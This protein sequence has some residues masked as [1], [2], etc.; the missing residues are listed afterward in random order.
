MIRQRFENEYTD[1]L[2]I[3]FGKPNIPSFDP[4]VI[5]FRGRF[6]YSSD[7]R[8]VSWYVG[9]STDN[10]NESSIPGSREPNCGINP[11][12]PQGFRTKNSVATVC[13]R[14]RDVMLDPS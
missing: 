13:L 6:R 3:E 1:R 12:T 5:S 10:P 11:M 7:D 8:L 2:A 9:L 4:V 14:R